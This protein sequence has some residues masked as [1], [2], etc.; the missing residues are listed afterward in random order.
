MNRPCQ[1]HWRI[2]SPAGEPMVAAVCLNCHATRR[3]LAGF[4]GDQLG[5][6]WR[7]RAD[8]EEKTGRALG[9]RA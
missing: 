5:E 4:A 8:R 1:H 3:Y 2:D 9:V 7:R 6:S